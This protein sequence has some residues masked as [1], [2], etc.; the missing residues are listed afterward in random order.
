MAE[1][2]VNVNVNFE[3]KGFKA[4]LKEANDELM[5]AR[6]QFGVLSD[7]ALK[8]AKSVGELRDEMGDAKSQAD[9][10]SDGGK[11]KA[12]TGVLKGVAG[13]FAA[14]QGAIGLVSKDNKALEQTMLKV[15]SAMALTQG[16]T[17]I[18]ELGDSFKNLQTVATT[19]LKGIKTGIAATGIGL[20]VVALG[21]IVAYW[22]DI[23]A[24]VSGVSV[25]Q[26]ALNKEAEANATA[27]QDN[28]DSLLASE[29]QLK[30]AGKSE[31][32]I[33]QLKI[34]Q[35]DATIAD[36]RA[37]ALAAETTL[38]AQV[39]ATQRN[40]EILSGIFQFLTAPLQVLL[41]AVDMVGKA[42]GKDFG[43]RDKLNDLVS[44][45]VFDPKQVAEDGKKAKKAADEAINKL[46]ES[47]AGLI[48]QY[49]DK[50]KAK[51]E[52][53]RAKKKAEEEKAAA[54]EL[55]RIKKFNE[56]R[57]KLGEETAKK[58]ELYGLT[59]RQKEL[60][61][62]E[63]DYAAKEKL[64]L[65]DIETTRQLGLLK[66]EAIDALTAKNKAEDDKIAEDKKKKEEED[67]KD[68][69]DKFK[70][71]EDKRKEDRANQ[72]QAAFD[73]ANAIFE[74]ANSIQ[75][76]QKQREIE[77]LKSKGLSEEEA[78]RQTDEINK[79]YFEKN[80][81]VQ[82]GQALIQTLQSSIA[83]FAALAGIPVVGPGLGA[84]AAAA[85]LV[86]GYATVDKI[87]Q[88]SYTSSIKPEASKGSKY[89]KGGLL[90]GK[91]HS[92]GGIK[93]AMG[94]LEDGEFVVNREATAKNIDLLTTIN[95][96]SLTADTLLSHNPLIFK[97]FQATEKILDQLN[98]R[99]GDSGTAP[100]KAY[101]VASDMTSQQEATKRVDDIA[102]L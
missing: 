68:L 57:F 36:A 52:E 41:G 10:F 89:E 86:S 94:E 40:K 47:K 66:Q 19:A 8:A 14:V 81:S 33:Y 24:A 58:F 39:E 76:A 27:S 44:T 37:K 48:N 96:G 34:K 2:N 55:A 60:K 98:Q 42:L 15:Q 69:E 73:T 93:T 67:K 82:I 12:V 56:D 43:L 85:A 50:A 22:D 7:E 32:E 90:K 61:A 28:L 71:A 102:R 53:E 92:E 78:A 26:E 72:V 74:A 63:A 91:R 70:E 30:L 59:Q 64:A 45:A 88:T 46:E 51:R 79:K 99:T 18:S 100:V 95:K 16:L 1:E 20:L 25:E 9:A 97:R 13:G 65:G 80:K 17:A 101:V 49:N 84:I 31:E 6:K 75:E 83:A 3:T 54:D 5:N 11:F 35:Y 23:K 29:Q 87:R 38:N 77:A 21:L 4:Q 62:I